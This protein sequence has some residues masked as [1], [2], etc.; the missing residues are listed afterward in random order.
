M[1][2]Y[3]SLLTPFDSRARVDL[4]RL[5]AHVLWLSTQGVDG[6]LVTGTTGELPYLSDRERE[7]VHRTVLDAA[8]GKVV[9]AYTWDPNPATTAYLT[10]AAREQGAGA[11]VVPPPAWYR[12]DDATSRAWFESV[13]GKGIPVLAMH[14]PHHIATPMTPRLYAALRAAGTV[15][16]MV[17]AGGDVYRLERMANEDPGVIWAKGD[18]VLPTAARSTQLAGF[19][20]VIAN[21]WPSFCM[22]LFR[23]GEHQLEV[24]LVERLNRVERAGGIRALKAL[25]RMGCRAPMIEPADELLMGLPP[26]EGP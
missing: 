9:F 12:V 13:A 22:R 17:D 10:D 14:D 21:V 19:V 6:F 20:S 15:T 11:V 3:T 16:G 23:S 7:A 8:R 24:A 18:A 1:A 5:R 26:A 4:A 25:T 2:F